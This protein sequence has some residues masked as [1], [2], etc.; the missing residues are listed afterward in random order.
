MLEI[1]PKK[2]KNNS[3]NY[4][5][6]KS[7][8]D[9]E[10]ESVVSRDVTVVDKPN[11]D[12]S[13]EEN[14]EDVFIDIIDMKTEVDPNPGQELAKTP[15]PAAGSLTPGLLFPDYDSMTTSLDE[16]SRA[17]FSPLT[18]ASSGGIGPGSGPRAF[19]TFRCPHK[20]ANRR[21]SSL[22]IR[23]QRSNVIGYVD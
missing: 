4:V 14:M 12:G 17:N 13:T 2:C 8:K 6:D 22:G 9:I 21:T 3:R 7:T 1:S 18:K 10:S 23:R 5:F 16:W 19:H 20:K 11:N 15:W